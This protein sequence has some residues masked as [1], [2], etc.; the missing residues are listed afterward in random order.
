MLG[1]GEFHPPYSLD[2]GGGGAHCASNTE[3]FMTNT[4]F[5]SSPMEVRPEWIDYNGHLNMAYYFLQY[6]KQLLH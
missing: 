5:L 3:S 2:S 6:M 1:C 4:P